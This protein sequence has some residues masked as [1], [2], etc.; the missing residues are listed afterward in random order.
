MNRTAIT[1]RILSRSVVAPLRSATPQ[2]A[3]ALSVLASSAT[4]P[5]PSRYTYPRLAASSVSGAVRF[6]TNKSWGPPIV[7]YEELKPL[8][9]Q[10]NDDILIVDV[11]EN[12]EVALGSIPSAVSLPLSVLKE[13]LSSSY[14]PGTFQKEHAFSKPLPEQKMIFFCRSGKRSATACQ[15]AS[16]AGY[17]NL[18]NYEGSWLDWTRREKESD[19]NGAQGYKGDDDD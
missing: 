12:D 5:V 9:E 19:M 2:A 15:L 6:K 11:R 10:P 18:R 13:H 7:T 3:R 1:A 14:N 17:K 4:T 8:T 16:E